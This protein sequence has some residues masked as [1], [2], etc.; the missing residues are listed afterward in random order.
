MSETE[1]CLYRKL[2]EFGLI[3]HVVVDYPRQSGVDQSSMYGD[4]YYMEAL[5]RLANKD[6]ISSI[7]LLY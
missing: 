2:D 3:E 4:Y 5:Y 1:K 6:N 7:K